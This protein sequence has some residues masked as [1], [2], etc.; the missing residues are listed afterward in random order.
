MGW[1]LPVHN[2]QANKQLRTQSLATEQTCPRR[3]PTTR[4]HART[5][6]HDAHGG[7]KA[8]GIAR[9]LALPGRKHDQSYRPPKRASTCSTTACCAI[10]GGSLRSTTLVRCAGSFTGARAA[11]I[12][13][14]PPPPRAGGPRP[15]RPNHHHHAPR[16]KP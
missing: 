15:P 9:Y 7:S 3:P 16:R 11:A 10:A 12:P 1:Y 4:T 6:P 2:S 8:R 13:T 5:H 14:Q